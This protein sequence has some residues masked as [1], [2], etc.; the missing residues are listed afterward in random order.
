MPISVVGMSIR[1]WRR[2]TAGS[3]LRPHRVERW[4]LQD[5][6]A[7][8]AAVS[9][10]HRALLPVSWLVVVMVGLA[11]E[12]GCSNP[13]VASTSCTSV[14]PNTLQAIEARLTVRGSLRNGEMTTTRTPAVR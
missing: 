12:A 9:H 8:K 11:G 2:R 13:A 1:T 3:A 6:P 14:G 5:V 10:P 4:G 7:G